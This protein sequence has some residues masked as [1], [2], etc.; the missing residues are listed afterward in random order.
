MTSAPR[1][2][3]PELVD[4]VLAE[5]GDD[6]TAVIVHNLD[7]LDAYLEVLSASFPAAV[8]H[9]IAIK[10]M[11][12]E[13]VLAHLVSGGFGLEAAS[14]EEVELALGAG[15]APE[16]IVFDS[17]VK[18]HGEIA[19]CCRDLPGLLLNVNS[20]EE[21]R[22]L[23]AD[24][25]LRVGVRV[26]PLV[27]TDA[28]AIFSVSGA[29]SKFGVPLTQRDDLLSASLDHPFTGLHLHIA[30]QA[31]DIG[32]HLEAVGELVALADEIDTV[33]RRNGSTLV[34]DTLDIGGGLAAEALDGDPMMRR[35]G[36]ALREM[37]PD[38][39][40]REVVTEFG[41]WVHEYAGWT[42]SRVEYVR[43][44]QTPMAYLHVG[45]DLFPR[46]VYREPRPF[47]FAV[48][49]PDG[50]LVRD[51]TQ[52]Y[53]L[54]GPLCFA[55]D[56]LGR[57]V[58]L[59]ALDEGDWLIIEGTGANT[60]GLWSRHCSRQVPAVMGASNDSISWVTPRRGV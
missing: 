40:R 23:P 60:L 22:R 21:L 19:R 24:A 55:G 5:L 41:Q 6:D 47:R 39:F 37:V 49:K 20:L 25:P 38:L 16:R 57:D 11:P 26:N 28:P 31:R 43:S 15:S 1:C 44:G 48:R 12:H 17:P 53:D 59:P 9:A 30:S 7:V 29:G 2:V 32:P 56:F 13:R 50:R 36:H 34:I 35:Y 46:E 14:M 51:A 18:T 4:A 58:A 10:T 33:R 54:A 3:T 8:E 52:R 42:G 27:Q 45:A